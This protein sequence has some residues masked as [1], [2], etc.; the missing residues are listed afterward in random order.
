MG[1]VKPFA[2]QQRAA[3]AP[4]FQL[5]IV[6]QDPRLVR[7][8]EGPPLRLAGPRP[9]RGPFPE[10]TAPSC[11]A[12]ADAMS[13]IVIVT[14]R[15]FLSRPAQYRGLLHS[16]VSSEFDR[17]GCRKTNR[18]QKARRPTKPLTSIRRLTHALAAA[19]GMT[20]NGDPSTKLCHGLKRSKVNR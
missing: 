7:R 16:C 14:S 12:A 6:A 3:L 8:G 1:G 2:A 11:P 20:R 17:E 19:A 13:V 4:G 10:A 5:V 15:W 18:E 9:A